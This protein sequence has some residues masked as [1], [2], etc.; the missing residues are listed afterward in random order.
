LAL[1]L[2][3]VAALCACL[4]PGAFASQNGTAK[5]AVFPHLAAHNL[6]K[7]KLNLPGDFAG[8]VN[9][10]IVS[11]RPEQQKQIDTWMP[12]AEALQHIH[13]GFHWY[14]LPVSESENFI[15]R[16]WNNSSMRS[17]DI[18]PA[19]WPWIVPLYVDK[20]HLRHSLQITSERQVVVL[21]VNQMGQVLWRSEG[22][23]TPEKRDSLNR[24]VTSALDQK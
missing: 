20:N 23:M 8:Q 4:L 18:D 21:L 12:V 17:D 11:F 6:A 13:S 24:I 10:L 5:S 15:F 14:Q 3:F 22:P 9:L 1:R 7:D 2:G 16:W 19:T